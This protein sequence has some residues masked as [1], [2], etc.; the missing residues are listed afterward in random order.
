MTKVVYN[1]C[2]GGFGISAAAM[3]LFA[4]RTGESISDDDIPR[5]HPALIAIVEELGAAANGDCARLR[6]EEDDGLYRIKDHDG[7]EDVEWSD[8]N[9]EGWVD[10]IASFP[11]DLAFMTLPSPDAESVTVLTISGVPKWVVEE[12]RRVRLVVEE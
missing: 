5:H 9:S 1:D 6:I 2:Y 3:S 11:V 10:P 12:K 8:P 4:Q 7:K